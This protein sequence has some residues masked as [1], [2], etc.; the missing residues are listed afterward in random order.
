[1]TVV[2]TASLGVV[3][4]VIIGVSGGRQPIATEELGKILPLLPALYTLVDR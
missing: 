4:G 2:V 3:V 1:M